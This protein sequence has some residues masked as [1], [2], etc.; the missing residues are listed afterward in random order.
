MQ[1]GRSL[2]SNLPRFNSEQG[3]R[4]HESRHAAGHQP[5]ALLD[6]ILK[7]FD[8]RR[9]QAPFLRCACEF[10]VI[11]PSSVNV[12]SAMH[13]QIHCPLQ[14]IRQIADLS[15]LFTI[16]RHSAV[17][18]DALFCDCKLYRAFAEVSAKVGSSEALP[19]SV[20]G[21]NNGSK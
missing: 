15:A 1:A 11:G 4:K 12:R 14:V 5:C 3:R 8:E 10:Q 9:S 18:F 17:H 2:D 6:R 20:R 19:E 21:F 16:A 7:R 13:V